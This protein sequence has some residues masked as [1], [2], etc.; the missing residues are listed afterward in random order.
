MQNHVDE[1]RTGLSKSADISEFIGSN[2]AGQTAPSFLASAAC[3]VLVPTDTADI[4]FPN[5]HIVLSVNV[6]EGACCDC[7]FEL[8]D[9]DHSG[10]VNLGD[11]QPFIDLLL[12]GEV[13]CEADTN[14]DFQVDLRDVAGFIEALTGG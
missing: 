8:G 1:N 7:I 14:F 6:I 4:G 11:V 3:N 5:M 2:S 12:S 13:Q 9:V 10:E